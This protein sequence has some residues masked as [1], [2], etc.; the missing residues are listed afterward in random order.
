LAEQREELP[1][2]HLE[3]HVLRGLDDLARS[4]G[5]SVLRLSTF[6]MSPYS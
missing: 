3:A 1:L 6:S 4:F 5:Y 2:R